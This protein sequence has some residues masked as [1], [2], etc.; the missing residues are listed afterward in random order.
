MFRN[1]VSYIR[2]IIYVYITYICI[3]AGSKEKYTLLHTTHITRFAIDVFSL[4]VGVPG[5]VLANPQTTMSETSDC[6]YA[7][8]MWEWVYDLASAGNG[9]G[10]EA[11]V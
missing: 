6:Y 1:V 9:W 2:E 5:D 11:S 7:V 10:G 3:Y 4:R 8:C